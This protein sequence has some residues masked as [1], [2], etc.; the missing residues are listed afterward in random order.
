MDQYEK[1]FNESFNMNKI[2][3]IM[4]N[5]EKETLALL[6]G[7]IIISEEDQQRIDEYNDYKNKLHS[8]QKDLKRYSKAYKG[9]SAYVQKLNKDRTEKKKII[10]NEIE[11]IKEMLERIKVENI[12]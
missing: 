11:N 5:T 3:E 1:L 7:N 6:K 2:D 9:R 12:K 4:I 10:E 8:L